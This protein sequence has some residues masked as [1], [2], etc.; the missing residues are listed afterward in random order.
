MGL[1]F[2]DPEQQLILSTPLEDVSFGLRGSGMAEPAIA[3]RCREVMELLNLTDLGDKPIHQLSL[4]QKKT[5]GT[6]RCAGYGAGAD[7]AG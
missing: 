6:R 4:G 5:H 1:V 3:A 7:S 2:Q